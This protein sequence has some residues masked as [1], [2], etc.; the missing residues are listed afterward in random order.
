MI[1]I[2]SQLTML[3]RT[4][5]L[6]LA[7]LLLGL[8]VACGGTSAVQAPASPPPAA[9][10]ASMSIATATPAP[11]NVP[12]TAAPTSIPTATTAP[13][14]LPTATTAP[15]SIPPTSPATSVVDAIKVV[16]QRANQEQQQA[17]AAH[18]PTLMRDTATTAYYS[19]AAQGLDDLLSAGVTA[20]ELVKLDWGSISIQGTTAAQ[21][22]TVETWRTSF[23]D[24]STLQ[25]ADTNVYTLV[26]ENN[27]WK[28]QD[29]QHPDTR[30]LQP[31][32]DGQGASP[33]PAAPIAPGEAD[34][35]RNWAGYAATSGTFTAVSGSWTIPTISAG[36]ASTGDAT[37]VGIGGISSHDLIQAGTDATIKSGK[38]VY[39]AWIEMLPQLAQVVPLTVGANDA[40]NV[41]I[42]QQPDEKWH[43][44]IRNAT[45][46]QSYDK[47]VTY[48][49][50]RSSAEWIEEAPA[51]GRRTLL[52]LDN[53]GTIQFTNAGAVE[54][55]QQRSIVQA[56]GQPIT[57]FSRDGQALAQPSKIGDDGSSF[58]VTRTNTPA[59]RVVPGS[60]SVSG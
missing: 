42:S 39:T 55:G 29:D 5:L 40:I 26:R 34:Q 32:Q 51:V 38:V 10:A 48:Q 27:A 60:G 8:L 53:F 21:A 46:D 49:S 16:I 36:R 58:S 18:D 4:V 45:T 1:H 59:P 41:S 50:S 15:T 43:I 7:A 56:N 14:S 57:M 23:A 52:P 35:S 17:L 12:A 24:G 33:T 6:A 13:T 44:R 20:I 28:V 37:W 25:Q 47:T 22:S 3:R 54:D 30:R 31:P 11:A 9:T 2:L 19:Q